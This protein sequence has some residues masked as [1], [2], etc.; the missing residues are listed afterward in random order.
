MYRWVNGQV[1]ICVCGCMKICRYVD[2]WVGCWGM[3][4]WV[5]RSVGMDMQVDGCVDLWKYECVGV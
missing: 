3:D 5:C 1:A 2:M 4:V